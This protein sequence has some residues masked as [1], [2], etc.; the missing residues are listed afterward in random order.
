MRECFEKQDIPLLQA[1]IAKMDEKDAIYHMKRAVD[2]GL[3]VP[4]KK[5]PEAEEEGGS[6][7]TEEA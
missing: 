3:W 7:E 2:S 1:T 5:L 6:Q 4:E